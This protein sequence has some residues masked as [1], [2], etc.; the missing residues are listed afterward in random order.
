MLEGLPR[1]KKVYRVEPLRSGIAE[2]ERPI[3]FGSIHDASPSPL[4]HASNPD[5][6]VY[7]AFTSGTTGQPKG[8]MHSDNTILANGRAIAKDWG[9]EQ[10]T[11]VYSFSPL[12][13][14]IGIVGMAVAAVCGGEFVAHTPLDASRM[15][16]RIVET[17]ATYVLG[18]PTHAI[19]L[20]AEMRRRGMARLGEVK[21][22][23]LAARPFLQPPCED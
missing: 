15:L 9:F 16:D 7:L 10:D 11:I 1:L 12:S 2:S 14:N 5:R 19:D 17:G 13:H 21:A 8:V 23:Q 18:V 4:A 6:I 22:F 20:L 3:G